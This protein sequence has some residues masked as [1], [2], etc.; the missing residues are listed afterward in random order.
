MFEGCSAGRDGA[1]FFLEGR[2]RGMSAVV[3]DCYFTQSR[4]RDV[5]KV[6]SYA[7]FVFRNNVLTQNNAPRL[8]SVTQIY[9]QVG[10]AHASGLVCYVVFVIYVYSIKSCEHDRREVHGKCQKNALS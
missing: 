1:A 2:S 7:S 9:G 3:S 8:L 6:S 5:V 10:T 4:G